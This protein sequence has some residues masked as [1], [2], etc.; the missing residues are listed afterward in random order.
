[1]TPE[2]LEYANSLLYY[3]LHECKNKRQRDLFWTLWTR[4][5]L[6]SSQLVYHKPVETWRPTQFT[7]DLPLF[8]NWDEEIDE[9]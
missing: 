6:S 5:Y 9:D 7:L 4:D 8:T 3:G 2:V 1:M